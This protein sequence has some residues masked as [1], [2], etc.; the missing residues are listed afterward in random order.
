MLLLNMQA[1]RGVVPKQ[2]VRGIIERMHTL[3]NSLGVHASN[4]VGMPKD[5]SAPLWMPR[6][7]LSTSNEYTFGCIRGA[8][9]SCTSVGSVGRRHL[10]FLIPSELR[11][12]MSKNP[13]R[14]VQPAANIIITLRRLHT[15]NERSLNV[16]QLK[17]NFQSMKNEHTIRCREYRLF[18]L[19][20]R[21]RT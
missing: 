2:Q 16:S 8:T 11:A 7:Q 15:P 19:Q 20:S 17:A 13:S 14:T 10:L 1:Y 9:S 3:L 21:P 6:N 5:P 18:P 12:G 4:Q